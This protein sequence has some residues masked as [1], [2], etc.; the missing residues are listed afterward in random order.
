MSP[1]RIKKVA[2]VHDLSCVGRCSLTVIIP[3][4]ACMGI[5]ACPLPTALLSTHLGGF[6]TVAFHDFTTEMPAF[7]THWLSEGIA[8]DCIY[9]GFLASPEQIDVVSDFIDKFS[10]N[11][12]LVLVDPVMGDEGKLYSVYTAKMQE[13]I[14]QLVRKADV[15][16][17]NYTEAC[18][19]LDEPYQEIVPRADA[20]NSWLPRLSALGPPRV[21][22]TGVPLPV[23]QLANLCY[24]RETGRISQV[25]RDLI[26]ARYPGTGDIFASVLLGA[27][28]GGQRLP[29]AMERADAFVAAAVQATYEAG[30]PPR[31]GI[32]LEKSLHRLCRAAKNTMTE[33]EIRD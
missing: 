17:P 30:T 3:V 26:P 7:F 11:H 22:I 32:L 24:E 5:Q 27:L 1:S 21:V 8:F 19:L 14:R 15:I 6:K 18:F 13:R 25:V 23:N 2:A 9:S 29:A 20:L 31:E 16:T 10:A 4:L 12:P 28:L 33:E